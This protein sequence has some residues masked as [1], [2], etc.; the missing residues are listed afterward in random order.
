MLQGADANRVSAPF[1]YE[2]QILNIEC[3][4]LNV[5]VNTVPD[6]NLCI[7]L[8]LLSSLYFLFAC[9][10]WLTACSCICIRFRL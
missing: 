6:W 7:G 10:L 8:R 4:M 5:E 3:A 9:S 1:F 2:Y